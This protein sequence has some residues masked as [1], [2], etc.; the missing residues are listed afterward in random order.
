MDDNRGLVVLLILIALF[1]FGGDGSPLSPPPAPGDGFRFLAIR[2]EQEFPSLPKVQRDTWQTSEV[3]R[4]LDAKCVKV[5]S[6]P[7]YRWFDDDYTAEQVKLAGGVWP[8][9]YAVALRDSNGKRPWIVV[10]NGK[11]GV[12][13]AYP[14]DGKLLPILKKYGGE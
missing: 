10:S 1:A 2:D 7:E 4:Y 11:S 6:T 8:E 14:E 3:E 9:W 5:G 12:S 13:Q